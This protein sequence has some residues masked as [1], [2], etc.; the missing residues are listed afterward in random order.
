MGGFRPRGRCSTVCPAPYNV[1]KLSD[2][3][4][5]VRVGPSFW[6]VALRCGKRHVG[7]SCG[8][9]ILRTVRRQLSCYRARI[10]L[11][12]LFVVVLH[13]GLRSSRAVLGISLRLARFR[14]QL[15]P[16]VRGWR[17]WP[18]NLAALASRTLCLPSFL[19][20]LPRGRFQ[21]T[22][23]FALVVVLLALRTALVLGPAIS[24]PAVLTSVV[25]SEFTDAQ[26][27]LRQEPPPSVGAAITARSGTEWRA[28]LTTE[29]LLVAIP[30]FLVLAALLAAATLNRRLAARC[31]RRAQRRAE[32]FT[33][34]SR[35]TI[36][37]PDT[38]SEVVQGR[39]APL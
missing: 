29:K 30:F 38:V 24:A 7:C 10:D 5:A 12:R 28:L 36:R 4:L 8:G 18:T 37:E 23:L 3:T 39:K 25:S 35:S 34:R 13:S 9:T 11:Y 27:G 32:V 14:P 22:V 15:D 17:A 31:L 16:V 26:E 20:A 2:R 21:P 1:D 19:S 6:H 33:R